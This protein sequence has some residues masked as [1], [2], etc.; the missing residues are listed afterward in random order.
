MDNID[1]LK[2]ELSAMDTQLSRLNSYYFSLNLLLCSESQKKLQE[3]CQFCFNKKIA[4]YGAGIVGKVLFDLMLPHVPDVT[5]ID[6]SRGSIFDFNGQALCALDDLK[7]QSFDL[8]IVSLSSAYTAIARDL[9][10][11]GMGEYIL[12]DDLILNTSF[13]GGKLS[14]NSG[15]L[16]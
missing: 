1:I 12:V 3:I 15:L 2:K 6:K 14:E 8:I 13:E 11:L 10:T 4:I 5:V 9:K 16:F 7:D